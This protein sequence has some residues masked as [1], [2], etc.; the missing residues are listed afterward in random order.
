MES[1]TI[2]TPPVAPADI[3]QNPIFPKDYTISMRGEKFY[4]LHTETATIFATCKNLKKAYLIW[5]L[6]KSFFQDIIHRKALD[7]PKLVKINL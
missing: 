6:E 5:F 2:L 4:K 1:A 7:L 3:R